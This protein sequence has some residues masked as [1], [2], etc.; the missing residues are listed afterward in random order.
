M[1]SLNLLKKFISQF[2]IKLLTNVFYFKLEFGVLNTEFLL[3]LIENRIK[4]FYFIYN[5]KK[6]K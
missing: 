1:G 4:I 3:S 2:I 6:I 5:I